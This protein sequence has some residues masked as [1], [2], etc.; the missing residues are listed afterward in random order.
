M[1]AWVAED[2]G[3]LAFGPKK[4]K[5]AGQEMSSNVRFSFPLPCRSGLRIR[6]RR[7]CGCVICR[8]WSGVCVCV[9]VCVFCVCGVCVCVCVR[10]R[11]HHPCGSGSRRECDGGYWG[12]GYCKEH[13][14]HGTHT[15]TRVLTV[16]HSPTH[17]THTCMHTHTHTCARTR[18]QCDRIGVELF[19]SHHRDAEVWANSLPPALD[20]LLSGGLGPSSVLAYTIAAADLTR[21]V[22]KGMHASL[23]LRLQARLVLPVRE[24]P[25]SAFP[26]AEART[27][28]RA[29]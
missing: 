10:M 17:S 26:L 23:C 21:R 24:G 20:S 4:M 8:C 6:H 18:P 28:E 2:Q 3:I 9:C 5:G 7:R 13:A 14:W 1:S 11:T 15:P 29:N 12:L 16:L 25:E 19:R 22:K 27:T